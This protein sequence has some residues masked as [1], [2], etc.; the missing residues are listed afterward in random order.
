MAQHRPLEQFGQP[1]RDGRRTWFRT[2]AVPLLTAAAIALLALFVWNRREELEAAFEA[3]SQDFVALLLLSVVGQLANAT[4]YWVLY[5]AG[6][7]RPGWW[8]NTAAFNAG[9]LGN[10]LPLQAGSVYRLHF[11]KAVYRIPYIRSISAYAQN[12]VITIAAGGVCGLIGVIA[13]AIASKNDFSWVMFGVSFGMVAVAITFALLPLPHAHWL[14]GRLKHWWQDFHAGWEAVRRQPRAAGWVF[15]VE[16]ARMVVMAARLALAFSLLGVSAPFVLFLVLA[17]VASVSTMLA[18]TP[19]AIGIREAAIAA[20]AL[21]MG[22]ELPTG[23]LAASVDRGA[24]IIVTVALGAVGYIRTQLRLREVQRAA[25]REP[26]APGT[27]PDS[28]P[29][30]M[31][32]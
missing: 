25:D 8:D 30:P 3:S 19:G 24:S 28:A 21:A 15:V 11:M 18:F 27:D 2:L 17:P 10:Y 31:T 7:A 4:E 22:F 32:G 12:L 13:T 20:A 6:G 23:L 5:R 16:S 29:M 9:Q 14:P 26:P 1:R